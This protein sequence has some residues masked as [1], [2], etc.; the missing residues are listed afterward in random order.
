[1][2]LAKKI[3]VTDLPQMVAFFHSLVGAAAVLTCLANYMVEVGNI[4]SYVLLVRYL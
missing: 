1:M 2:I 3:E 4:F